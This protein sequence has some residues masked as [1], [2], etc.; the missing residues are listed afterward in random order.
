[1]SYSSAAYQHGIPPPLY[2]PLPN[3]PS[4]QD[5]IGW[6]EDFGECLGV[7]DHHRKQLKPET[8][9]AEG[10]RILIYFEHNEKREKKTRVVV[11]VT[12]I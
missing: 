4:D 10:S 6:G 3:H 2:Y 11:M 12:S 1:M 5:E 8:E 7:H 9:E